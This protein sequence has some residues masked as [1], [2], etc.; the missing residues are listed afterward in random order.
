MEKR[1]FVGIKINPNAELIDKISDLKLKLSDSDI[2]WV[3]TSNLH[4]TLVFLGE[5]NVE[6]IPSIINKL[7]DISKLISSFKANLIGFGRFARTDKTNVIWTGI[8]DEGQ[9]AIIADKIA[10]AMQEFGFKR[11]SRQFKPHLT[12][13]RIRTSCNEATLDSFIKHH[14][15]LN[16]QNIIVDE[17]I[18]FESILKSSGS[19]YH[20]IE[21]F[22]F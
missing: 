2:K 16:L 19:I 4:I 8:F 13:G 17:F 14:Q 18:L 3:D 12:L 10:D 15:K 11:E 9:I 22:H 7:N 1:L 21:R 20:A 6:K 5:A